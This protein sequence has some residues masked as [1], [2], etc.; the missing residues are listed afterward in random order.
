MYTMNYKN[1][2][3]LITMIVIWQTNRKIRHS[4]FYKIILEIPY[5]SNYIRLLLVRSCQR[6]GK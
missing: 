6:G 4:Y 1:W 2:N 3:E 5:H